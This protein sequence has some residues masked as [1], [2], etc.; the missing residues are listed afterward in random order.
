MFALSLEVLPIVLRLKQEHNLAGDLAP[1]YPFLTSSSLTATERE[2]T[3]NASLARFR[4]AEL[5]DE[6]TQEKV[7][8]VLG[9]CPSGWKILQHLVEISRSQ[10]SMSFIA[11]S[12][13]RILCPVLNLAESPLY[14]Y[15]LLAG[16]SRNPFLTRCYFTIIRRL[17]G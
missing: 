16:S 13:S 1:R 12:V 8:R 11:Y 15:C 17:S 10:S 6:E 2:L 14:M 5:I 9:T 4:I 3:E 7:P